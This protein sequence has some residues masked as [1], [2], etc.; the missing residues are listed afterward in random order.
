MRR[1]GV[2]RAVIVPPPWQRHSNTIAFAAARQHPGAFGVMALFD[3]TVPSSRGAMAG[4]RARE[5]WLGFRMTF[6]DD[7]TIRWLDDGAV[8]WFW[9][10]AE[11]MQIPLM[12]YAPRV[13]PTLHRIADR[14]P[15][16]TL[17]LD[18]AAL[19]QRTRD[20]EAF[21]TLHETL[22]LARHRNVYVKISSLPAYVS[23]RYPFPSLA[24]PVRRIYD[25]FGPTRMMW[26]S[27]YTKLPCTYCECIDHIR[28]ELAFLS[29]DDRNW[30][31]GRSAAEALRWPPI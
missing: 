13:C 16:L 11:T 8:D 18:H 30:I 27:D 22:S 24:D 26:G 29:E 19:P 12:V 2:D 28:C 3:P 7:R 4:W 10:A 21:A 25:A 6:V 5:H 20:A 1:C 14:H 9:A 17:I 23:E 31:L 15:D